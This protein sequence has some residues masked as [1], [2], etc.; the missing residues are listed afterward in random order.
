MT[1]EQMARAILEHVGI[2]PAMYRF[3]FNKVVITASFNSYQLT[4]NKKYI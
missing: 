4:F 2:D 3:G 1:G